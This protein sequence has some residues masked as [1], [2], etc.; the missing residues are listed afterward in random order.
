MRRLLVN[1][2]RCAVCLDVIQSVHRHDWQACRCGAIFVDGGTSYQRYGADNLEDFVDLSVWEE[3][4][5]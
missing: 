5:G 3:S 4:D 2:A 1:K